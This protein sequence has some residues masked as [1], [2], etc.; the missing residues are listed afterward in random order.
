MLFMM[1]CILVNSDEF[2][3]LYPLY[4]NNNNNNNNYCNIDTNDNNSKGNFL[5]GAVGCFRRFTWRFGKERRKE[6]CLKMVIIEVLHAKSISFI[7]NFPPE[8]IT[9]LKY[10]HCF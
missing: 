5:R 2:M 3:N 8:V 1:Q 6:N 10:P 7:S 9:C 4:N